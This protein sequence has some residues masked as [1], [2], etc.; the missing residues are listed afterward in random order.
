MDYLPLDSNHVVKASR[1]PE[2]GL[3]QGAVI[4]LPHGHRDGMTEGTHLFDIP[5][6]QNREQ[7][8]DLAFRAL[9]AYREG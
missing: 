3:W 9:K 7:L 8:R 5:G 6:Q 1:H 2:N 4:L